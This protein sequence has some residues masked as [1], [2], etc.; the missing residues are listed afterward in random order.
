VLDFVFFGFFVSLLLYLH[1]LV[2]WGP[3]RL[4]LYFTR[5]ACEAHSSF[6][7]EVDWIEIARRTEL[8]DKYKSWSV[9]C[10]RITLILFVLLVVVSRLN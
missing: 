8:G 7:Y 9:I 1:C 4:L 6:P 10:G 5:K 3:S 2:V